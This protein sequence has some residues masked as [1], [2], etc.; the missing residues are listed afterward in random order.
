MKYL[1]NAAL[2]TA[3][4][5]APAFAGNTYSAQSC[6]AWFNKIDRNNDGSI[7]ANEGSE[8]YLARITLADQDSGSS[9]IMTRSFFLAECAIGSLGRPQS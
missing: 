3:M 5:M 8:K 6:K 2:A 9:Y 7:S 4:M 1:V